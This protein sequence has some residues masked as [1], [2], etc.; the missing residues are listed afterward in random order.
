MNAQIVTQMYEQVVY[1]YSTTTGTDQIQCLEYCLWTMWR[2]M[3]LHLC[4]YRHDNPTPRRDHQHF[5]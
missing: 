3:D 1:K 4:H 2:T 5:L